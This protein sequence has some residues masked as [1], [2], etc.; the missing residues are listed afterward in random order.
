MSPWVIGFLLALGG[1]Q[2]QLV[3]CPSLTASRLSGPL[4]FDGHL[5]EQAWLDATS[6][7]A[8]GLKKTGGF[9]SPHT[10]LRALW[11]DDGLW[12]GVY[13]GDEDVRTSDGVRFTLRR[14]NGALLEFAAPLFGG[15]LPHGVKLRVDV[16]GTRDDPSDFDEEWAM[17][18][19][20]SWASLG[21]AAPPRQVELAVERADT[22]KGGAVRTER[23]PAWCHSKSA[24]GT[25]VLRPF[26]PTT[27][28]GVFMKLR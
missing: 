15:P 18:V 28:G 13:G 5:D 16:D 7:R 22:P 20:V 8:W 17:E 27:D 6:S 21:Y 25:I 9:T 4:T 14:A 26:P 12:L 23:W 2:G 3:D 19:T 24:L 10:E 11:D 1:P